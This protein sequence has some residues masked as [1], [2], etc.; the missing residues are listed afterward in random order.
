MNTEDIKNLNKELFLEK[1]DKWMEGHKLAYPT[2]LFLEFPEYAKEIETFIISPTEFL[3]ETLELFGLPENYIHGNGHWKDWA[4]KIQE[5]RKNDILRRPQRKAPKRPL[6]KKKGKDDRREDDELKPPSSFDMTPFN[7][8]FAK[9]V[10]VS[11]EV[12]TVFRQEV[13]EKNKKVLMLFC[14]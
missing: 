14:D 5:V 8:A 10:S 7:Q 1:V 9:F 13:E 11:P 6:N 3:I 2:D 4:K 12:R